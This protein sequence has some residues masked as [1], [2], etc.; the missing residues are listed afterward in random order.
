MNLS[1][2]RI[3]TILFIFLG[4][5]IVGYMKANQLNEVELVSGIGIDKVDDR[6]AVLP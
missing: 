6:Y 2:I 1:K 4:T 5:I 3:I